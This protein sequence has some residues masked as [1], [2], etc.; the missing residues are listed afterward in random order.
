MSKNYALASGSLQV[1]LIRSFW[2]LGLRWRLGRDLVFSSFKNFVEV[3]EAF[4]ALRLVWLLLLKHV[5][6]FYGSE[7]FFYLT[8]GWSHKILVVKVH[9]INLFYCIDFIV[10]LRKVFSLVGLLK[11][12]IRRHRLVSFFLEALKSDHA[13]LAALSS[14]CKLEVM[15]TWWAFIREVR[16][17]T[18]SLFQFL[19]YFINFTNLKNWRLS[20]SFVTYREVNLYNWRRSWNWSASYA[21]L[22]TVFL[23]F[24]F[25]GHVLRYIHLAML[26]FYPLC[27]FRL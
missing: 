15:F 27:V 8:V 17:P 24:N 6:W 13:T 2:Y 11:G 7:F 9:E 14:V 23:G 4:D 26:L 25:F 18:F 10:N 20:F 22:S 3:I 5:C 16:C 12:N 21:A 1:I 19:R